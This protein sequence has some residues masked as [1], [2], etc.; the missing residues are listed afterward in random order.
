MRR[1]IVSPMVDFQCRV[2]FTCVTCVTAM[3]ERAL[4][5]IKV[6]PRSTS[7]LSSAFFI[8]RL[9]YLRALT[10]VAKHAPVE[11]NLMGKHFLLKTESFDNAIL[12][13]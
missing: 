8:F 5:S 10:N 2:F 13:F 11:I 1:L 7:R 6:E 12:A 9:F 4:V 3:P